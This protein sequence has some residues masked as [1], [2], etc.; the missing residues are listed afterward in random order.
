MAC[1][2]QGLGLLTSHTTPTRRQP[3]RQPDLRAKVR[4]Q[5]RHRRHEQHAAAEP[6]DETLGQQRLP[7]FGAETEHH[8]AE[9]DAEAADEQEE[10]E[11]SSVKNGTRASADEEDAYRPV[12][13]SERL[14]RFVQAVGL[15]MKN[16]TNLLYRSN[17]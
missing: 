4:R 11:M 14:L 15:I 5:Y 17:P 6:D 7:E 13:A 12:K 10:A 2:V 3:N 1:V 8:E 9:D 16:P